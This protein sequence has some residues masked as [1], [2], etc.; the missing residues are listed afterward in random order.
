MSY[1]EN[2]KKLADKSQVVTDN[3]KGLSDSGLDLSNKA[4]MK[5][6]E[7]QAI[8]RVRLFSFLR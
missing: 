2:R 4:N 6:N 5:I 3:I 1:P 7:L 8:L